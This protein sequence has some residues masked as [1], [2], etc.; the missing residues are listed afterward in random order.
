MKRLL[1]FRM[2]QSENFLRGLILLTAFT[3]GVEVVESGKCQSLSMRDFQTWLIT[4]TTPTRGT[5]GRV[6]S[7]LP[8]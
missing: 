3:D 2:R 8:V 4:L 6:T 7:Q 5:A 1:A